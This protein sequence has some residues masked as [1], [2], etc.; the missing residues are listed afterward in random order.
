[1]LL[2]GLNHECDDALTSVI[3]CNE[4]YKG[5]DA[6]VSRSHDIEKHEFL[7]I[8]DIICRVILSGFMDQIIHYDRPDCYKF[9]IY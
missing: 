7:P 9:A 5:S 1:M 6:D 8:L 2:A 3:Y 4:E